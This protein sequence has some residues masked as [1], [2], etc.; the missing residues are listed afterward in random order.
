MNAIEFVKKF[1]LDYSRVI[2]ENKD[3]MESEL[4]WVDFGYLSD[5]AIVGA[6]DCQVINAS[7][8][9]DGIVSA[10]TLN[11]YFSTIDS[12]LE[13]DDVVR[14]DD[15]KQI[16]DAFELV[17][18]WGGLEDAKLYDLSHCKSKPDSMGYKLMKAINL[19]EKCQ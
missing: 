19:V 4:Y 15:L 6:C 12:F 16:V 18:Q 1:D 11:P 17:D 5:L 9:K 2:L 13:F 8:I 7:G 10:V 14:L 3:S